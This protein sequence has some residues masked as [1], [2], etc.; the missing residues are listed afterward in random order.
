MSTIIFAIMI[1]V[2]IAISSKDVRPN[3]IN[4]IRHAKKDPDSKFKSILNENYKWELNQSGFKN[5]EN[6]G[7]FFYYKYEN[8]KTPLI[9]TSPFL[10]CIQSAL[11]IAKA[12]NTKLRIEYALFEP[13]HGF[14]TKLEI[15]EFYKGN[16]DYIDKT[17]ESKFYD[18]SSFEEFGNMYELANMFESRVNRSKVYQNHQKIANYLTTVQKEE[19]V[20]IIVVSHQDEV[21]G[22]GLFL[23]DPERNDRNNGQDK[24]SDEEYDIMVQKWSYGR[25]IKFKS[26]DKNLRYEESKNVYKRHDN[27]GLMKDKIEQFKMRHKKIQIVVPRRLA[28]LFLILIRITYFFLGIL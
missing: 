21:N 28:I 24:K 13:F 17:Y 8:L 3:E 5:A 23:E 11:P 15:E 2:H 27:Y 16:E 25:I 26:N 4:L 18:I 19:N 20:D 14:P 22:I 12:L 6:L 9:Y 10:R 1:M 7:V